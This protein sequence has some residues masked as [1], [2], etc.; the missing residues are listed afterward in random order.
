MS[1]VD[2]DILRLRLARLA[3]CQL[4]V[5]Q[6]GKNDR[7]VLPA[8]RTVSRASSR[9]PARRIVTPRSVAASTRGRSAGSARSSSSSV[10]E[11]RRHPRAE[12]RRRRDCP[13][14][15][16]HRRARRPN[17]HADRRLARAGVGRRAANLGRRD[18]SAS[19]CACAAWGRHA[20]SD[21]ARF[22]GKPH[23]RTARRSRRSGRH[24]SAQQHLF[25][26]GPAESCGRDGRFA[27]STAGRAT[28]LR[29]RCGP[30]RRFA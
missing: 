2:A 20:A 21:D 22:D 28:R 25:R 7:L 30:A 29:W 16:V 23:R 4:A 26:N 1:R 12:R 9:R 18:G 8:G 5:R 17:G 13:C 6:R 27:T 15:A 10:Y 3:S 19:H 24:R 14:R 11:H